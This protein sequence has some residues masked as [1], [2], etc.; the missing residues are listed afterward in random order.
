MDKNPRIVRN[1]LSLTPL[2][3]SV[4]SGHSAGKIRFATSCNKKYCCVA[5]NAKILAALAGGNGSRVP[6]INAPI[7]TCD[8]VVYYYISFYKSYI[9][10]KITFC[11]IWGWRCWAIFPKQTVVLVRM[12]PCSSFDWS[13][14]K[15]LNVST[16]RLL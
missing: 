8:N 1:A 13:F 3:T 15:Y 4:V 10:I 2:S 9:W 7:N 12:P 11:L 14:A 16:L 5:A 6:R